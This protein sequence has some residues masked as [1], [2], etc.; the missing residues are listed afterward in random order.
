MATAQDVVSAEAEHQAY[1][2]AMADKIGRAVARTLDVREFLDADDAELE[3]AVASLLLV[4]WNEFG[5]EI[6]QEAANLAVLAGMPE[7]TEEA[8]RRAVAQAADDVAAPALSAMRTRRDSIR[9]QLQRLEREGFTAEQALTTGLQAS[10]KEA[11]ASAFAASARQFVG[12]TSSRINVEVATQDAQ[13]L[14]DAEDTQAFIDL[15]RGQGVSRTASDDVVDAVSE[16]SGLTGG[17]LPKLLQ[18]VT[19]MDESV[20]DEDAAGY[21][22]ASG[23]PL[24]ANFSGSCLARHDFILPVS[25]W[26]VEGLPRDSRLLCS[27]FPLENPRPRCR[28]RVVAPFRGVPRGGPPARIGDAVRKGKQ[29]AKED[30]VDLTLDHLDAVGR[31]LAQALQQPPPDWIPIR[32]SLRVRGK[33]RLEIKPSVTV[34]SMIPQRSGR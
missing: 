17:R 29:R 31:Q 9:T 21:D 16:S 6:R 7:P 34:E 28:C 8:V 5:E 19:V 30:D 3:L 18:W 32:V 23:V 10:V 27:R 4:L 13:A 14:A 11:L 2:Q 12:D 33:G 22:S 20:C 24:P 26:Q 1:A 25:D 15:L